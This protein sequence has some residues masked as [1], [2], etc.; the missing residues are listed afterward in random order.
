MPEVWRDEDGRIH[1]VYDGTKRGIPHITGEIPQF[2]IID[3]TEQT[4]KWDEEKRINADKKKKRRG[5]RRLRD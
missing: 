5:Y 1:R 3:M 2:P 4:A